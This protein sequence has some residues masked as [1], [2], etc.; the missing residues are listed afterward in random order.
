MAEPDVLTDDAAATPA[1]AFVVPATPPPTQACGWPVVYMDCSGGD[2]SAYAQW[3]E[4]QQAAAQAWFEAQ[5]I[6]ILWN[7]TN[8]VFGVC[9]VELRPCREGCAGNADW[10]ST[11]WGRGP[12]FDPAFPRLGGGTGG[13]A[14][15]PVLVSGQWFNI[16]CGCLSQCRCPPSGPNVLS[17][18]GP[19]VAVTEVTIDGITVDPSTYRIDRGRWLVRD[20]EP[21]PGCQDM[22]VPA[23]AVGSFVVRYTRGVQVPA[24]GQIAA[25]RLACELAMAACNDDDCALPDNWQTITRQGLTVNADPNMDGTQVTGIWSIDEWIKQVNRPRAYASVRSVDLPNLR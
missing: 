8:G 16:T 24:G 10:A 12:R 9:D 14:F 13:G 19:V 21:W 1:A 6:D 25:G 20:G 17:L 4:E 11:F 3:P 2:C 7:A 22:N 5:A 23:D 15:Y 18:P